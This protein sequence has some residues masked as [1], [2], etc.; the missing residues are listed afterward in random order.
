M[1]RKILLLIFPSQKMKKRLEPYGSGSQLPQLQNPWQR[2][3]ACAEFLTQAAHPSQQSTARQET[4][5]VPDGALLVRSSLVQVNEI[6]P[7][8]PR[9]S[10]CSLWEPGTHKAVSWSPGGQSDSAADSGCRFKL[11]LPFS[12]LSLGVDMHERAWPVPLQDCWPSCMWA[13]AGCT[14]LV[15]RGNP[16]GSSE[17]KPLWEIRASA[18]PVCADVCWRVNGPEHTVGKLQG[19]ISCL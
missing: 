9:E 19:P 2:V 14:V 5:Q 3:P 7:F 17:D 12:G 8:C 1:R 11:A 18:A 15:E 13:A 4:R 16:P 10:G 6:I